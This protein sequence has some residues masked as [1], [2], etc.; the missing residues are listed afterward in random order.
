[1]ADVRVFPA[2]PLVGQ[3]LEVLG[4]TLVVSVT[5]RCDRPKVL[6]IVLT[7][8]ELGRNAGIGICPTCGRA[9]H[10]AQVTMDPQGQLQFAFAVGNATSI[11]PA[12]H[13]A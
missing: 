7:Q 10:L 4:W 6:Q 5:C 3:P 13:P 1:M 9:L 12:G 2:V 11:L 8:N